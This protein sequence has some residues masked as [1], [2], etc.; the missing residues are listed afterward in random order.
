MS[1]DWNAESYAENAR[2]VS[3]F[4]REIVELLDP[5]PGERVL[6]LGCGD[7]ALT[8]ELMD[9]GVNVV[10]VDR[11]PDMVRAALSRGVDARLVGG[12]ELNFNNEFDAV[13]SNAALHWMKKDPD[14]VIIGVARALKPK[15]RFVGEFGGHG[16]VA[17][18]TVA[19]RAALAK[20]GVDCSEF[21]PWYFPTTDEYR[22]KLERHG[23]KVQRIGAFS[24]PTLLPT[25]ME[26]WLQTFANPFF[27]LCEQDDIP[28]ILKDAVA[29][30]KPSL[31]DTRGVWTADYVRLRFSASKT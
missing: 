13:F 31:Q 28:G 9:L 16:N 10:G 4:G 14:A 26:G 22:E 25:G 29:F 2:F 6:D 11:S 19:L 7:G 20:R 27:A 15:G 5:K 18:I 12:E 17:A 21:T 24:R 3:E 8:K 1:Q 23:F 30:L